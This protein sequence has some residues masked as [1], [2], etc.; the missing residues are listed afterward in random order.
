MPIASIVDL[1]PPPD[2]G[3]WGPPED[4]E[5]PERDALDLVVESSAMMSVF[6]AEQYRRVEW[7]RREALADAAKHGLQL[8]EV[9]ERSVRLELAAALSIT[10]YAAAAL[11]AQRMRW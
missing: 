9:T 6:A 1:E 5:P 3:G 4:W 8:T 10:E 7:M 11:I 2:D